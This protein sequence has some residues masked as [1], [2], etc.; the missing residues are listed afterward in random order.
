MT[1]VLDYHDY[2]DEPPS[3]DEA[4]LELPGTKNVS[5]SESS[6][7]SVVKGK[8]KNIEQKKQLENEPDTADD[9]L[10]DYCVVKWV[11]THLKQKQVHDIS[12]MLLKQ[13]DKDT[14][15]DSSSSEEVPFE[16]R[17]KTIHL[18]DMFPI[19]SGVEPERIVDCAN[20]GR[21]KVV[22]F[23]RLKPAP[24]HSTAEKEDEYYDVIVHSA[25]PVD[26]DR[27]AT[28]LEVPR[29]HLLEHPTPEIE[30]P[31]VVPGVSSSGKK[32]STPTSTTVQTCLAQSTSHHMFKGLIE[33]HFS[34]ALSAASDED[35]HYPL[36]DEEINAIT[37]SAGYVLHAIK[38]KLLKVK[39]PCPLTKDMLLCLDDM[40]SSDNE[41]NGS[42][43]WIELVQ[44]PSFRR[45]I[46]TSYLPAQHG[47]IV[48]RLGHVCV[49][50]WMT[51]WCVGRLKE[52]TESSV[53]ET[54]ASGFR[55]KFAKCVSNAPS[56]EYLG[57]AITASSVRPTDKVSA[58]L[59]A[60]APK[61]MTELKSFLGML[62]YYRKFLPHIA[63]TLAPL[64]SL[65]QKNK[66][67]MWGGE[68]QAAFGKVKDLLT[69]TEVLVHYDP[70][71]KLLLACDALPYGV[72]AVLSHQMEDGSDPTIAYASGTLS[73]AEKKAVP[74]LVSARIQRWALL[75]SSYRYHISY[76]AG[77]LHANA[78]CLSRLPVQECQKS[79]DEVQGKEVLMLETL[80]S[81]G[82]PLSAK[83][84]EEHTDKD[85]VLARVK[86]MILLGKW[87]S[88]G[89]KQADMEPYL[90]PGTQSGRRMHPLGKSSDCTH[91]AA[92]RST[93]DTT[94]GPSRCP[95][96]TQSEA[97]PPTGENEERDENMSEMAVGNEED[98]AEQGGTE[99]AT[100]VEKPITP[101]QPEVVL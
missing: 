90:G 98:H 28:I 76:K 81:G 45:G 70:E 99:E 65:M 37:Y 15:F 20:P 49:Y 33:S 74:P 29:Q 48:K 86:G 68:Q 39:T 55:L 96:P 43:D 82:K 31:A 94:R 7:A 84:K 6:P 30:Q 8:C 100:M 1:T 57:Y 91:Q 36:T 25:P 16:K 67:W 47:N 80:P 85:E 46:S 3:S 54:A 9:V 42:R 24:S 26:T 89:S 79:E 97:T 11:N 19:E 50:I 34:V 40:I 88:K 4:M 18:N 56:V 32:A 72:A 62:N 10:D 12:S 64:H 60:P 41:I 51:Y 2:A 35:L 22:H 38:K 83:V 58:L 23:N 69:S 5:G 78:D 14:K 66:S 59:K 17:R 87:D 21:R 63:L 61:N 52:N 92:T 73:A 93:A 75:L 13:L 53:G 95:I 27:Q 77:K 44:L 101:P 71:R